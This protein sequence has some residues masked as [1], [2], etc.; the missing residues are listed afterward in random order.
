MNSVDWLPPDIV[1]KLV[2]AKKYYI[3]AE[4]WDIVL[5]A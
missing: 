1:I 4:K 3:S 2:Q 5:S